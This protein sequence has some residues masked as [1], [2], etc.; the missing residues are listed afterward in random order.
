MATCVSSNAVDVQTD[1]IVLAIYQQIVFQAVPALKNIDEE[2]V[3]LW[4]RREAKHPLPG[5]L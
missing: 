1:S 3:Y 2:F 4:H 5:A